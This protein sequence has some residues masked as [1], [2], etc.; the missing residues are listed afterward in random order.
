MKENCKES[1]RIL[2][3]SLRLAYYAEGEAVRVQ[4]RPNISK[5][6]DLMKFVKSSPKGI[7]YVVIDKATIGR[8]CP[9]FLDAVSSSDLVAIHVQPKLEHSAYGELIVYEVKQ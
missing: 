8:Y 1:P 7:D 2:T 9:D 6:D 3:D 5:Y 4:N